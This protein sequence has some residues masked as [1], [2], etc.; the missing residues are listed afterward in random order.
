MF[1]GQTRRRRRRS[2]RNRRR[3]VRVAA[4]SVIAAFAVVAAFVC[5][6]LFLE[7]LQEARVEPLK[8]AAEAVLA[9][10]VNLEP[11]RDESA[12]TVY[13]FSVIPGGVR[14]AEE[15]AEAVATDPAVG[16]H[17]GD[18][19]PAAMHVETVDA[20]RAA[21]MS[22]RIG[23]QITGPSGSSRFTRASRCSAT[24]A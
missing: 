20:P 11:A 16:A 4:I 10:D 2:S 19:M 15:F 13:P 8:I 22:Y 21:Y 3:E 7:P 5:A 17:Y 14:S 12:R 1:E 18:V 23:D 6:V 24:E 9:H